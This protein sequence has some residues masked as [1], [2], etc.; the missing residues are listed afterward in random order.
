MS[1]AKPGRKINNLHDGTPNIKI[2]AIVTVAEIK[3]T[4][5]APHSMVEAAFLS[6]A[7]FLDDQASQGNE[8]AV[9]FDFLGMRFRASCGPVG[10]SL[11]QEE[12]LDQAI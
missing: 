5:G 7:A 11:G 10:A 9:F 2:N 6:A 12:V 8:T 4:P 3:P 1:V